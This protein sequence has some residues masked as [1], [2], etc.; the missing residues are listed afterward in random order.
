M[1]ESDRLELVVIGAS[2]GGIESVSRLLG[3]LG[4]KFPL[5]IVVAQHLDPTHPSHLV[6]VL[7]RRSALPVQTLEAPGSLE[8]GHVY[9]VPPGNDAEISHGGVTLAE[10][11]R[12]GPTPSIDRL[13]RSAA[14][15]YGEGLI[16]VILSGAGTDGA[17]GAREVRAQGGTVLIEDPATASY[18]SMPAAVPPSLV[19]GTASAEHMAGLLERIAAEQAARGDD[20]HAL[21][22]ILDRVR[23]RSGLDFSTYK[24]ATIHRRLRQRIAATETDGLEGYARY[25]DE[26]PDELARLVNSFLIKVTEFMR[27]PELFASLGEG[28]LPELCE[29]ARKRGDELRIWSAGCATGEEAYSIAILL[30]DL[31]GEAL[32]TARVRIFATDI[33]AKAIAHARQGIYPATALASLSAERVE[34]YFVRLPD[35]RYQVKKR[36]RS[37]VVFGEHDLGQRAP[38]PRIDLVLCRNVLIYFTSELQRRV[39]QLFAFALREGG[40]LVLGKAETVGPLAEFFTPDDRFSKVYVRRGGRAPIPSL[41]PP[42]VLPRVL[43]ARMSARTPIPPAPA[44]PAVAPPRAPFEA[45][46]TSFPLGVVI[47]DRRYDILEINLAARR[48]LAIH[49]PALGEDFVHL[50]HPVPHRELLDLIEGAFQSTSP[51]PLDVR[52]DPPEAG[53]PRYLQIACFPQHFEAGAPVTECALVLVTDVTVPQSRIRE[54]EHTAAAE[55]AARAEIG[56]ANAE[57]QAAVSR[58]TGENKQLAAAVEDLRAARDRAESAKAESV[59]TIE[60]LGETNRRLT[61]A[62]EELAATIER[63]RGANEELLVRAEEAQAAHEEVETLNEEFQASNE[64]LEALNEELQATVEELTTTN[65][66]LE[67]RYRDNADLARTAQAEREKLAATLLGIGDALVA[68]DASGR[69][70]FQNRA[71]EDTLG[72]ESALRDADGRPLPPDRTPA[73]RAARCEAFRTEITI[74]DPSGPRRYFEAVGNPIQGPDGHAGGVVVMR[75]ITDRSIRVLQ[76]RFLAMASHELRTPLVPLMGY[77]DMLL[78]LLDGADPRA[79]R[80][81]SQARQEV[82]R[83]EGL[84]SDLVDVVRLQ[85]GRLTLNLEPVELRTVI[86]RAAQIARVSA[87]GTE[88]REEAGS[89]VLVRGDAPRLEQVVINLLVNAVKHAAGT[90][91]IDVRIRRG[92]DRPGYADIVVEDYGAGIPAEA[93]PHIFGSFYQVEH[94]NRP[95]RGGMGLGLFIAKEIVDA[96]DG[97]I[98][99]ESEVGKGTRFTVRL[100]LDRRDSESAQGSSDDQGVAR[101]SN[102]A[103]AGVVREGGTT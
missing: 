56:S 60:R 28:I 29:R 74:G 64:E 30:A 59:A 47:I 22:V 32:D 69:P 52:V 57:L 99:V 94:K 89:D 88:I 91:R 39:L 72:D 67:A 51:A 103:P 12:P 43:P 19:D 2:A 26:H 10:H 55:S 40:Y 101:G 102:E 50:A 7:A 96:H 76:D 13:L 4:S 62:N 34:K 24:P 81:A 45:V 54:L 21:T 75:D 41:Q 98:S 86:A 25:L 18:P 80:Y 90:P 11:G 46:L 95:S 77:L 97:A 68:V 17:D 71:Y 58:A 23:E 78:K 100:P 31:L 92:E 44:P 9:V 33:D 8:P 53:P 15:T 27:D 65:S 70:L 66:E 84:V 42:Q 6:D 38:F 83:L 82:Q 14:D 63:L 5:P 93:L 20:V 73:A 16:A 1:V 61:T 35:D 37:C 49:T 3:S 87:G 48:L 79:R 85:T 36:L